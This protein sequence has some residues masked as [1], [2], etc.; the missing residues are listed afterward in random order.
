MQKDMTSTLYT[1]VVKYVSL[2]ESDGPKYAAVSDV[3]LSTV[4]KRVIGNMQ[5]L[6]KCNLVLI[7]ASLF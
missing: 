7:L 4:K 1:R 5:M 2:V 3:E 6:V